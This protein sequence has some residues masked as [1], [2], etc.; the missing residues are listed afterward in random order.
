MTNEFSNQESGFLKFNILQIQGED[1][2]TES[3]SF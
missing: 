2:K 1:T 3:T